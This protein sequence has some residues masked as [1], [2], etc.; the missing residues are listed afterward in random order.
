MLLILLLLLLLLVRTRADGPASHYGTNVVLVQLMGRM[1]WLVMGREGT[2]ILKGLLRLLKIRHLRRG[3]LLLLLLLLL[4][5]RTPHRRWNQRSATGRKVLSHLGTNLL[6]GS[7]G[8]VSTSCWIP[9]VRRVV[10]GK[11]CGASLRSDVG[12]NRWPQSV[13]MRRRRSSHRRLLCREEHRTL[14]GKLLLRLGWKRR[15][16]TVATTRTRTVSHE[17]SR[18]R[19][20]RWLG[21]NLSHHSTRRDRRV[22]SAGIVRV[23]LVMKTGR[24]W[25]DL[26][27][28]LL[29][30]L[31]GNICRLL[32][33]VRLGLQ[34]TW[35]KFRCERI[36]HVR[37][38]QLNTIQLRSQ[39]GPGD[40]K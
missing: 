25:P 6:A 34:G 24:M 21:H 23:R 30:V 4:L 11:I 7:V 29:K 27:R 31:P 14:V 32:P 12:R 19:W 35:N 8:K 26:V 28:G 18:R 9:Q 3:Q 40:T 2:V 15:M 38:F 33:Q 39:Q 13:R 10:L 37:L 16:S 36:K 20:H 17:G 1:L 5:N 22:S